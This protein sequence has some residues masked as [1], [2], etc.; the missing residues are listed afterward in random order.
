MGKAAFS[1][2]FKIS[3]LGESTYHYLKAV[4]LHREQGDLNRL[5]V[6]YTSL[7]LIYEAVEDYQKAIAY[8]SGLK[9]F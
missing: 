9:K 2:C 4:Q 3:Y 6:A 5:A 1:E 8:L 7:G